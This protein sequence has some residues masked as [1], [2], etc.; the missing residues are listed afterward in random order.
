MSSPI[1]GTKQATR[2]GVDATAGAPGAVPCGVAGDD[3]SLL[4]QIVDGLFG[5]VDPWSEHSEHSQRATKERSYER[6]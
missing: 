5:G 6:S 2:W 4:V 3:D 1:L